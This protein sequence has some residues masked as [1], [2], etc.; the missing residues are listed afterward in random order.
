MERTR[1]TLHEELCEVLGSRNC[2]FSAPSI[3][4]YPCIVYTRE[5]PSVNFADNE[6]YQ[7]TG[8]WRITI[9]DANPDSEIPKRLQEHFKHYCS[10]EQEYSADDL[11]HFVFMLYY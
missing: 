8:G 7:V 2:Y 3:L 11:R 4:Q 1:L 10:K 6:E 9:V 5:N